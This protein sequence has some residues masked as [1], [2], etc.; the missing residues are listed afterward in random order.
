MY[1]DNPINPNNWV[2]P[3]INRLFGDALKDLLFVILK[4]EHFRLSSN[5]TYKGGRFNSVSHRI[6]CGIDVK[7]QLERT[8]KF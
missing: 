2:W 1:L 3:V 7:K 5:T 6:H 4:E 8:H